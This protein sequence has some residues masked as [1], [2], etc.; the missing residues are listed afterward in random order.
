MDLGILKRAK[1]IFKHCDA[2]ILFSGA[3]MSADCGAPVFRDQGG[4]WKEYPPF[5]KLGLGFHHVASPSALYKHPSL[6]LGFYQHRLEL[7]RQLKP[8]SGYAEVARAF[9]EK[10]SGGYVVTSN[11]DGMHQR[12]GMGDVVEIHGS[13][14]RWQC[15][16]G[17]CS[18]EHGLYSPPN[19]AF[20]ESTLTVDLNETS[21]CPECAELL[22]PNI[23][24]YGD[25]EFNG[26]IV[27]TQERAFENYLSLLE[28]SEKRVCVLEVGAGKAIPSI[29]Y[30]AKK[31]AK[32]FMTK[33][34]RI[35]PEPHQHQ[36]G[37]YHL[38]VGAEDGLR[39]LLG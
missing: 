14:H 20:E 24:L 36:Y 25:G 1:N 23:L 27:D 31:V 37:V 15:S 6:F 26:S 12:A 39:A 11:V 28:D 4:F 32:R 16:D 29:R 9:S 21:R 5:E 22:R 35:N 38:S 8:H 18:Y 33:V 13:I 7:Y 17:D 3:G 30:E 10:S 34:I 2:V 19:L